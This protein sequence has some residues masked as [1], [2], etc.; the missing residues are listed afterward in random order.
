[1]LGIPA[2]FGKH[3][4]GGR[5]RLRFAGTLVLSAGQ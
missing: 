1:M 4:I 5:R 2:R 3:R